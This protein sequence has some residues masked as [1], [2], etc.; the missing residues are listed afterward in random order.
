MYVLQI[1][2]S[3]NKTKAHHSNELCTTIKQ[4]IV[5]NIKK[6]VRFYRDNRNN[7]YGNIIYEMSYIKY[8]VMTQYV[9]NC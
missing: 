3:T 6:V 1:I 2:F 7:L 9:R 5:S 8:T 4:S